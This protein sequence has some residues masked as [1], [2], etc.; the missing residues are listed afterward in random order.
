MTRTRSWSVLQ[1]KRLLL[2]ADSNQD[3]EGWVSCGLLF[4]QR[5][6]TGTSFPIK[7]SSTKRTPLPQN[8]KD[9][10]CWKTP[11]SDKNSSRLFRHLDM[12]TQRRL[13]LVDQSRLH[14]EV[15]MP[16]CCSSD[17]FATS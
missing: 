4:C 7:S 12:P 3:H 10:F 2:D 16:P 8:R 14:R 6:G 17:L 5:T 15:L 13:Q 11:E 1:R 9:R